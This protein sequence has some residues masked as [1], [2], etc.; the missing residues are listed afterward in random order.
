MI[1]GPGTHLSA[2]KN[3]LGNGSG[4][5]RPFGLSREHCHVPM[6]PQ[7]LGYLSFSPSFASCIFARKR[8]REQEQEKAGWRDRIAIRREK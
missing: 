6:D 4:T 3:H 7:N 1:N 2:G 5:V 8:E